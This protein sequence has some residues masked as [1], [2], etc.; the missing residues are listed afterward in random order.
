MLPAGQALIWQRMLGL[1]DHPAPTT[2]G[3][4]NGAARSGGQTEKSADGRDGAAGFRFAPPASFIEGLRGRADAADTWRALPDQADAKD[5][6]R[7][8]PVQADGEGT[9]RALPD[10]AGQAGVSG[11]PPVRAME[12]LSVE[13][14]LSAQ[15]LAR[16]V[17]GFPPAYFGNSGE[18]PCR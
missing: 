12:G 17:A 18:D 15:L 6:R 11:S 3:L 10:Q 4:H 9:W 13:E 1:A 14:S 16:G 7:T 2:L 5:R 8:L